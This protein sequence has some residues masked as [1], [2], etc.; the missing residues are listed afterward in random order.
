MKKLSKKIISTALAISMFLPY[1]SNSAFAIEEI[2]D[3]SLFKKVDFLDKENFE[4]YIKKTNI[5]PDK[6]GYYH[7][8]YNDDMPDGL[9][10]EYKSK[11]STGLYVNEEDGKRIFQIPESVDFIMKNTKIKAKHIILPKKVDYVLSKDLDSDRIKYFNK[12]MKFDDSDKYVYEN[13]D[14]PYNIKSFTYNS[15]GIE[16][17]GFTKEGREIFEKTKKLSFPRMNEDGKFITKIGVGAFSDIDIKDVDL[18]FIKHYDETSFKNSSKNKEQKD[19]KFDKNKG[20]DLTKTELTKPKKLSKEEFNSLIKYNKIPNKKSWLDFIF[21]PAGAQEPI[22][23]LDGSKIESNTVSWIVGEY[24]TLNGSTQT[25]TPPD[26]K[27]FFVRVR[28]NIALS[29]DYNY[30]PGE[31]QLTVPKQIF[32]NRDG[33]YIGNITLSVS[34]H[35]DNS[36]LFAYVE[37]GDKVTIV[38]TKTINSASQAKFEYTIRDLK[39]SDI[40]DL[41]TGYKTDNFNSM[42]EVTTKK[43]NK[44]TKKSNDINCQV[45][46]KVEAKDLTNTAYRVY[47]SYPKDWPQEL[48]P[49]NHKDFVYARWYSNLTL[50]A[51]QNY[52]IDIKIENENNKNSKD[53]KIIGYE[54]YNNII[55]SNKKNLEKIIKNKFDLK[56][57]ITP[58]LGCY[59]AYP[60]AKFKTN[61]DYSLSNKATYKITS[62]DDKET[63]ELSKDESVNYHKL[64]F[65]Y[66]KGHFRI[67]GWNKEYE[68]GLNILKKDKNLDIEYEI[69]SLAFGLPWTYEGDDINNIENYQK[70]EYKVI[71]KEYNPILDYYGEDKMENLNESQY[72]YKSLKFES[73][74]S[75]TYKQVEKDGDYY[76]ETGTDVS[77]DSLTEGD[78]GYVPLEN[79]IPDINIYGK[80]RNTWTKYG[81]I[82]DGKKIEPINGAKINDMSIEFP[83]NVIAYKT[84]FTTKNAGVVY[85]TKPTLTIKVDSKIKEYIEKKFK[86]QE[87]PE[88]YIYPTINMNFET[89]GQNH[90]V[91]EEFQ[92]NRMGSLAFKS[93]L[94]NNSEYKNDPKN[95]RVN[96]KY[97]GKIETDSGVVYGHQVKKIKEE[98]IIPKQNSGIWY[99]LL[100]KGVVPDIKSIEINKDAPISGYLHEEPLSNDKI[101]KVELIKNYKNSGRTLMKIHIKTRELYKDEY[102]NYLKPNYYRYT[103]ITFNATYIWENLIDW[104]DKLTNHLVFESNTKELGSVKGY[105][106]EPDNPLAEENKDSKEATIE[107]PELLTNLNPDHDNPSFLYAKTINH[108]AVD[109]SSITSLNKTVDVNDENIYTKGY[110]DEEKRNVYENGNYIYRLRIENPDDEAT[111]N[112]IFYDKIESYKPSKDSK[113]FND[114]QWK[115][116]LQDV[117]ISQL[118]HIGIKPTVYYSTKKNIKLDDS[119]DRSDN[120][121]TKSD[122]WTTTKPDPKNITAIAVDARKSKNGNDFILD[123]KKSVVVLLKMK[124]PKI[125]DLTSDLN[126]E[127]WFDKN[128]K[129]NQSESGL[130]GGAHA[131]NNVSTISSSISK[132][133]GSINENVLI[134]NNYTK[135]G[136]KEN[137]IKVQKRFEDQSNIEGFRPNFVKINLLADGKL[138]D[139]IK[140]NNNNGWYHDFG[141]KFYLNDNNQIINYTIQ[142]ENA[143]NYKVT[144]LKEKNENETLF[145]VINARMPEKIEIKGVKTWDN[146]SPKPQQIKL[147]LYGNGKYITE[148]TID[149]QDTDQWLYDFGK[150]LKYKNKKP[151]KYTIREDYIEGFK[152]QYNEDSLDIHNKYE[153]YGNLRVHKKLKDATEKAKKE[154]FKFKLQIKDLN[155]ED[156]NTVYQYEKSNG[157]TGTISNGS[158]FEL[159]D[160]QNIL[161]K[162]IKM[163][164]NTSVTEYEK[165]GFTP[166]EKTKATKIY[167]NGTQDLRFT[168]TY[169][170]EKGIKLK[171]KK[172]LHNKDIKDYT[173]KYQLLNENNDMIQETN[174][175]Q[176]GQIEFS[177]LK[178]TNKDIGKDF[179]YKVIEKDDNQKSILYDKKIYNVT[180]KVRDSEKGMKLIQENDINPIENLDGQITF[181]NYYINLP[182]TGKS[183]IIIGTIIGSI[184]VLISI[185]YIRKRK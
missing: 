37:N 182:M 38:N 109:T 50:N 168:N 32:K 80:I 73:I 51:N 117:D 114:T 22:S 180:I 150:H 148:K 134:K 174:N 144:I 99:D 166:D 40:K 163:N 68:Y 8:K 81:T 116:L 138:I 131:Y 78:W 141:N 110:L 43:G 135:I 122:I 111:K 152:P 25:V 71:S 65:S 101:E 183:G 66:P 140:L 39:P 145:N 36:E 18:T 146:N 12:D 171:V 29:G 19:V 34:K 2:N 59:I 11:K 149:K 167:F 79:N 77:M 172:K 185:Y 120:D 20:L 102:G 113:D 44:I 7:I 158:D 160:N 60:K 142:E 30:K 17:T 154:K 16:V 52:N 41:V 53:S 45:D 13:P 119:N 91:N 35:P 115:G 9:K 125:R 93:T 96:I 58:S 177:E 95:R 15:S 173:F 179:K 88:S 82:K 64:E 184:L 5:K 127:N 123:S 87:R 157:E 118:E 132:I 70:K 176:N 23:E 3:N 130:T 47:S 153:P 26:N 169:F 72:S 151:I 139:S 75:F 6:D 178:F 103:T 24:G 92:V 85:T 170:E 48:K 108:I 143:D 136:F 156:D 126:I 159:M 33:N 28:S 31:I 107:N 14:N 67:K 1:L 105:K 98:N 54:I 112:I 175:N 4:N 84:D 76:K 56:N 62:D 27:N 147:A 46:T 155:N 165:T 133:D 90:F 57:N 97:S 74:Q 63:I 104:G 106:G 42:L 49:S 181:N 121:L 164:H 137:R 161:I 86:K 129:P 100:P 10:A 21:Q 83:E 128:L 89:N 94:Y 61:G 55:K 162:N 69:N 124:A